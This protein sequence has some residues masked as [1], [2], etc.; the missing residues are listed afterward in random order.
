MK[1][2]SSRLIVTLGVLLA[3]GFGLTLT[4]LDLSFRARA[5]RSRQ[6]VLDAHVVALIAAAELDRGGRLAPPDPMADPRLN[7]PGSGLVTQIH[8]R[9]GAETWR[10]PSGLGLTLHLDDDVHPGE[11]RSRTVAAPD[12]T[13]FLVFSLGVAWDVARGRS[14]DYVFTVTESLEPYFRELAR[15]RAEL[16][17]GFTAFT[18]VLLGGVLLCL[19]YLLA[20]LRRIETEIAEIEAGQRD[21]LSAEWPRELDGV[22]H[23]LNA[24]LSSDQ[25]RLARYRNMLGNLA[26]SLKTPLSVLRGALQRPEALD[27][28]LL[29]AHLDRVQDI[30]RHQLDRAAATA[31]LLGAAALPIEPAL[32]ELAAALAKV[33]AARALSLQ[34]QVAAG[35][36]Y[37]IDRGDLLELAG[38]LGDNASKWA[39]T[40][41]RL[42]AAAWNQPAWRRAGLELVVADDG[43]GIPAAERARVL[44]RGVRLDE[45][46]A[47]Q[48]LGL[49][50]VNELVRAYG[51]DFELGDSPLGGLAATIRLPGA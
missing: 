25:Q 16:L 1:S 45:R 27:R 19:R 24:L 51:G 38:N 14:R 6:D 37:P 36:C 12:G 30:V 13:R 33:H 4:L 28:A 21:K 8:L 9:R 42:Q 18:A 32:H 22:A 48:G 39:R 17:A 2:L 23:N 47:G 44:G 10:S 26:H 29:E 31:P 43:P 46:V 7:T 35:L 20:P 34:V 40:T 11:R 41:V 15:L 50:M 49:A 3:V 5:E